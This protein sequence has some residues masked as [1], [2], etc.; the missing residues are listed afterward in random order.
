MCYSEEL[1]DVINCVTITLL[2][3][4][5]GTFAKSPVSLLICGILPALLGPFPVH[6]LMEEYSIL[7]RERRAHCGDASDLCQWS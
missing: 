5:R 2:L 6:Q 7:P 3:T 1:Q 4:G